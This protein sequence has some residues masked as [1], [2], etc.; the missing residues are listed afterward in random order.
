MLDRN[1]ADDFVLM[2][3]SWTPWNFQVEKKHNMN[4]THLI[5]YSAPQ[6]SA[7]HI[8]KNGHV[9]QLLH[10][11]S[12]SASGEKAYGY[13]GKWEQNEHPSPMEI[14]YAFFKVVI[15]HFEENGPYWKLQC[16]QVCKNFALNVWGIFPQNV[17]IRLLHR[18][19]MI[20]VNLVHMNILMPQFI[21]LNKYGWI[22][23]TSN[24]ESKSRSNVQV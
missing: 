5:N 20:K 22:S 23:I 12:Q 14:R 21:V 6:P 7:F 24:S 4:K 8:H 17:K 11:S 13:S 9:Q 18:N 1:D 3:N 16:N 19:S 10:P 2:N 15:R